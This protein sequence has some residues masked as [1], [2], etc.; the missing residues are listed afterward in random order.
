MLDNFDS[1]SGGGSR[2]VQ[3]YVSDG[4]AAEVSKNRVPKP[5]C[6]AT[7]INYGDAVHP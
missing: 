5:H 2:G 1:I 3:E 6:I 7:R 4:L